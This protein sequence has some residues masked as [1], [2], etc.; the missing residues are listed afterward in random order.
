[1]RILLSL[2]SDYQHIMLTEKSQRTGLS[3]DGHFQTDIPND[4]YYLILLGPNDGTLSTTI[5]GGGDLTCVR[6]LLALGVADWKLIEID[7]Q[8][9]D[10]CAPFCGAP[11][12]KWAPHVVY[13]DALVALE[14]GS[15]EADHIIVDLLA[16]T[17]I[18]ELSA[19]V[20]PSQF[21]DLLCQNARKVI[22]GFTDAETPGILMNELLRHEF[23]KRGFPHFISMFND[24]GEAFFCASREPVDL[25][26]EAGRCVVGYPV[27]PKSGQLM[28]FPLEDKLLIIKEAM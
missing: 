17:R 27:Y 4:E 18:N 3:L 22:T 26:P 9:V 19:H 5:L 11:R 13:G 6:P 24:V 21:L 16:M 10:A 14:D 8:V 20:R 15:A 25:S 1:M 7:K 2:T 12:G 23:A 28:N